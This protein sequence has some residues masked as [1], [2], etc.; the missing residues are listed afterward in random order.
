MRSLQSAENALFTPEIVAPVKVLPKTEGKKMQA[1]WY[2]QL[3]VLGW[4]TSCK[5]RVNRHT[6]DKHIGVTHP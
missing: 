1:A 4:V 2:V 5:A 3:F 6:V